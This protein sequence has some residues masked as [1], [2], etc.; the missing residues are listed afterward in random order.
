MQV[1]QSS[2]LNQLH[3][4]QDEL[5]SKISTSSSASNSVLSMILQ[6]ILKG[7]SSQSS[8]KTSGNTT[9]CNWHT[10]ILS[11]L[12]SLNVDPQRLSQILKISLTENTMSCS[13]SSD[14]G[15]ISSDDTNCADKIGVL[16]SE[17]NDMI[18][19]INCMLEAMNENENTSSIIFEDSSNINLSNQLDGK[20]IK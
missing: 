1:N 13:S 2:K 9:N 8:G 15:T 4:I 7:S 5:N 6:K 3:E 12:D 10:T 19:S 20:E 11:D 17:S 16:S 18:E 14:I